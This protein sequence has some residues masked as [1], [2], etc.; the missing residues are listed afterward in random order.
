MPTT[1]IARSLGELQ[2]RT[3]SFRRFFEPELTRL[4]TALD[5][6][7]AIAGIPELREYLDV[8]RW[9]F[10][11][12]EYSFVL[13]ELS[14]KAAPGARVLDV[15]CGATPLSHVLSRRGFD[16]SACDFDGHLMTELTGRNVAGYLGTQV[17]YSR[18]DATQLQFDSASFD[19]VT[20]V[21]VL[22]HIPAPE[23]QK[24]LGEMFRV[25]T[26]G[27]LLILTID[28]APHDPGA[29]GR[30]SYNLRRMMQVAK[31]GG[32]TAVM[33]AVRR[34]RQVA[35]NVAESS[36]P[37]AI[38]RSPHQ[39][40]DA[41]QV[42]LNLLPRALRAGAALVQSDDVPDTMQVDADSIRR[43]WELEPGLFHRQGERLV[44]PLALTFRKQ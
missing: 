27:G 3:G 31:E 33:D 37:E 8:C 1:L 35:R 6:D 10:R 17:S 22:E 11:Q 44:L 18:Q 26:S 5:E 15:G 4:G 43:F 38:P 2:A 29:A 25:L 21:S 40:F 16:V 13:D 28:F 12:L 42:T 36:T 24:A 23:D 41:Q 7:H 9:P 32:V 20:C 14:Q 30:A 19:I 39:P 34:K